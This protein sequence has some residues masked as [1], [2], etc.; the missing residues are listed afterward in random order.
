MPHQENIKKIADIIL[1][2]LDNFGKKFQVQPMTA[3]SRVLVYPDSSIGVDKSQLELYKA[4]TRLLNEPFIAYVKAEVDGEEE[5]YFICK[6]YTPINYDSTTPSSMFVNYLA[7]MGKIVEGEIGEEV[8]FDDDFRRNV[9]VLEK[10]IFTPLKNIEWDGINN[11][12]FLQSGTYSVKSLLDFR[13]RFDKENFA[14]Y[15]EEVQKSEKKQPIKEF[16]QEFKNIVKK[17][18]SR[19]IVDKMELRNQPVLDNVQGEIFR[20]PLSSQIIITG[21]PG[22]GK[23]TT[24][25][26]RIAQKIN[27]NYIASEEKHLLKDDQISYF[28][29]RENWIMF[30]PT[31]LLKMFLKE[32]ISKESIPAPDN[33]VKTWEDE[34]RHIARDILS[35]L[36]VDETTGIYYTTTLKKLLDIEINRDLI[37]YAENFSIF[38]YKIIYSDQL[39]KI[40]NFIRKEFYEFSKNFCK[41]ILEKFYS[42]ISEELKKFQPNE[43]F[44]PHQNIEQLIKQLTE[45]RKGFTSNNLREELCQIEKR[46]ISTIEKTEKK[47]TKKKDTEA[48][49]KN[50][51]KQKSQ[52]QGLFQIKKAEASLIKKQDTEAETKNKIKQK[53]QLDKI[54]QLESQVQKLFEKAK[55]PSSDIGKHILTVVEQLSK[56]QDLIKN[57]CDQTKLLKN[58]PKDFAEDVVQIK[59]KLSMIEGNQIKTKWSMIEEISQIN[60]NLAEIR[61]DENIE[62]YV[63]KLIE[64]LTKINSFYESLTPQTNKSDLI[65]IEKFNIETRRYLMDHSDFN[66]KSSLIKNFHQIKESLSSIPNIEYR[67]FT[68]FK[69]LHEINGIGIG[70]ITKYLIG[71]VPGYYNQFRM[72]QLKQISTQLNKDFER[73]IK[74]KR[75]SDHEI[76]LL[77]F[78][79]LKNAHKIF[80]INK[81]WLWE[82]SR[83]DVLEKIKEKY[84]TLITV[85]E[86]TDFSTIQLGCMFYL[87][88]PHYKSVSFS[89][90]LMQ[91]VT[92]FGLTGWDECKYISDNFE[93]HHID[94]VYRQSPKLLKIAEIL[95]EENIG[96][97]PPFNSA[98]LNDENDPDPLKFNSENDEKLGEWIVERIIEIYNLNNRRL[99]SIAIFVSEDTDI[100]R[101]HNILEEPLGEH[102]FEIEDC[103]GGRIFSNEGKVRIFSVKYIKGLEF[104]SVFFVD[105]DRMPPELIDKYLYVG[106]TRAASFL[107]VTF[108]NNF[109]KQISYIEKCFIE[110]DW[111]VAD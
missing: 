36:R 5:I 55:R 27:P 80:E 70:E 54:K 100:N 69:G 50:K 86:A 95:Y 6:G 9:Y 49:T 103:P 53:S 61:H 32:S 47:L 39:R 43:V 29:N 92:S 13:K 1:S 66:L 84:K 59:A 106:L 42:F 15:T 78:V 72:G 44:L 31:N 90:D 28:F 8:E 33:M 41:I 35:L 22:T 21:A 85:D 93:E 91:R 10:N 99:P 82:D 12:F 62:S 74:D 107:A 104:E 73:E 4:Q 40:Y 58:F 25:I 97:P 77:I 2:E 96:H 57:F 63:F 108:N 56:I 68:L 75:I 20:L 16:E 71:G 18:L 46:C 3:G 30:T 23:T 67:V 45:I 65:L 64:Q 11:S 34:R 17:G 7:P 83:I 76:D 81:H 52:V 37:D 60:G 102:A 51:N 105:L 14:D 98:F 87:S 19:Q 109:P 38:S 89:G 94:K 24:I 88:H 26:K 111:R 48:E 79:M 110:G 101:I